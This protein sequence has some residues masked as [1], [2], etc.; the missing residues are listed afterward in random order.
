MDRFQIHVLRAMFVAL[1]LGVVAYLAAVWTSELTSVQVQLM[2]SALVVV[3]SVPV[4]IA[5]WQIV[6]SATASKK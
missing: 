3:P 6:S 4:A 5:I 1:I 2:L